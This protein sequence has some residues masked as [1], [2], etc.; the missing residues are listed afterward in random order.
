MAVPGVRVR[1]TV[2]LT[3]A[4]STDGSSLRERNAS[5]VSTVNSA[6]SANSRPLTGPGRTAPRA[7][8]TS[9]PP[10]QYASQAICMASNRGP[11]R[12]RSG[13]E[14]LTAYASSIIA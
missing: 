9:P 13:R 6:H 14:A 12:S 7:T 4:S 10:T 8:P 2:T 1:A 5:R 11:E 3:P